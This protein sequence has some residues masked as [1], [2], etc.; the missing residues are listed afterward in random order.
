MKTSSKTVAIWTWLFQMF[1]EDKEL[2]IFN[3]FVLRNYISTLLPPGLAIRSKCPVSIFTHYPPNRTLKLSFPM[4][5]VNTNPASRAGFPPNIPSFVSSKYSSWG[6]TIVLVLQSSDKTG[7]PIL[8]QLATNYKEM[9]SHVP[10][11]S[12]LLL[13]LGVKS[14]SPSSSTSFSSWNHS[15]LSE[16]H[17]SN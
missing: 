14:A 12:C 3:W 9:R 10:K 16:W 6:P 13:L 5:A 11:Q 1:R 7:N 15:C 8:P 17:L 2:D 4:K